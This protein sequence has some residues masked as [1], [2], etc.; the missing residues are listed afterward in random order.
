MALTIPTNLVPLVY[1]SID[2]SEANP[3][4][5]I[6]EIETLMIGRQLST[7]TKT[8]KTLQTLIRVK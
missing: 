2:N 6:Q 1:I 8:E 5:V 3:G 7:A 4:Q